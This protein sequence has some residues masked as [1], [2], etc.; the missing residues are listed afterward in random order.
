MGRFQISEMRVYELVDFGAGN[1]AAEQMA[2]HFC[3]SVMAQRGVKVALRPL[4]HSSVLDQGVVT[5]IVSFGAQIV[6]NDSVI[7]YYAG[8]RAF[9]L[10]CGFG[11]GAA[12]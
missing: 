11:S 10:L 7:F 1:R 3:A 5:R 4:S 6:Q 2:L 12:P 8:M 9:Y